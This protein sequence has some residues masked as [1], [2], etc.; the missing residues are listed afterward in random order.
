MPT[1]SA[2]R[3]AAL[4]VS[5]LTF[6][7]GAAHAQGEDAMVLPRGTVEVGAMGI[8]TN[9]DSRFGD[10]GTVSLGAPFAA[11]FPL[12]LLPVPNALTTSALDTIFKIT[13]A[14]GQPGYTISPQ[15]LEL[16]TLNLGLAADRRDAPIRLRVGVTSRL[17]LGVALPIE[18]RATA[19]TRAV[20]EDATLGTNLAGDSL[21]KLLAK[22]DPTL[23]DAGR[24]PLLPLRGTPA[25]VALQQQ[26]TAITGD[27][28]TLPLPGRAVNLIELNTG[29][30][31]AGLDSLPFH[32]DR[33]QYAP[34]DLEVSARYQ[35]L[36]TLPARIQPLHGPA[37]VRLA[38]E[39]GYR[40]PTGQG[41]DV[42]SSVLRLVTGSGHGGPTAALFGDAFTGRFWLTAYGRYSVLFKR[43]VLRLS[44]DPLRPY[45][46]P[47]APVTVS[48]DPGD[49]LELAL[50]PRYRLTDEISLGGRYAF[51]HEGEAR[52][53][54][55]P[56]QGLAYFGLEATPARTSQLLGAGMSY[57]TLAAF[58][59]GRTR[60]PFEAS[61]LYETAVT[62]SGGAPRI[63]RVTMTGRFFLQ[64]WNR[65]PRPPRPDTTAARTAPADTTAA[66]RPVPESVRPV[67]PGLE[68]PPRP[69]PTPAP[70]APAPA[71]PPQRPVVRAP[72]PSTPPATTP[73]PSTP[74]PEA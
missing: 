25:A 41:I 11:S 35:L 38:L 26:Y 21:A 53:D 8:Y 12:S 39:A 67:I 47:S 6:G 71:A 14:K 43:D 33:A 54:P 16:G 30:A 17:T 63:G 49:L 36:N 24:A 68:L 4:L 62:G 20:L 60:M 1:P 46:P 65:P 7:G 59:A 28:T 51:V 45:L 72:E 66:P 10:G 70:P 22:V 40:F 74:V 42:D 31:A 44:W 56:G 64:A 37:G 27:T 57:S 69:T 48:R 50:T 9:F 58:D 13:R 34:G 19:V 18:R 55:G 32:N 5:L 23:A 3:V 61:L 15:D 29:L 73:P 2:L 52:Y